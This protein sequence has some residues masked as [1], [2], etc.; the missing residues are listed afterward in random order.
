MIPCCFAAC[1]RSRKFFEQLFRRHRQR[2]IALQALTQRLVVNGF[3][4]QLL[5]DPFFQAHLADA[6]DVSRARPVGQAI[7]GVK[8]GFVF[9]EFGDREFAFEVFIEGDVVLD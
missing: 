1:S 8:D 5:L 6:L 3:G 9:G 4:M 2:W 7:H